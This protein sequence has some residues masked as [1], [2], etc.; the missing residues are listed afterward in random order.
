[1]LI[2]LYIVTSLFQ[3]E[4]G[5]ETWDKIL[6]DAGCKFTV[7]VTHQTYSDSLMMRIAESSSKIIKKGTTPDYFMN[8]FGRCF[9]RFFSNFG[10]L[11]FIYLGRYYNFKVFV[12]LNFFFFHNQLTQPPFL[13]SIKKIFK[14]PKSKFFWSAVIFE[15]L[16][17]FKNCTI[18]CVYI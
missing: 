16:R 8:F 2:V 15:I 4:Y 10:C 14:I 5:E 3:L 6:E 11:S 1:M 7:F 9:V 13:V 17:V 18:Q 12:S